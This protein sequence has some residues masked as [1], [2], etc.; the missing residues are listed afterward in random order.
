MGYLDSRCHCLG[1]SHFGIDC[2]LYSAVHSGTDCHIFQVCYSHCKLK[3][4]YS[5]LISFQCGNGRS[6][7]N[8]FPLS[9]LTFDAELDTDL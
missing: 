9:A 2:A 3:D 1:W 6:D 8:V 7:F 5:V 4:R